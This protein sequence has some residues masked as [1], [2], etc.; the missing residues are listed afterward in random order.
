MHLRRSKLTLL[1]YKE[2]TNLD[3]KTQPEK[4]K[5]ICYYQMK[6]NCLSSFSIGDIKQ[7][8]IEF[9]YSEINPSR[10]K[11]KVTKGKEKCFQNS[12]NEKG[13]LTFIP[14]QIENLSKELNIYWND[15]ETIVSDSELI[16]ETKFC[17]KRGFL[18]KI[19]KQINNCYNSNCYDACA[20]MMRRLFE[21][22]LILSYQNNNIDD[23]IKNSDGKYKMLEKIVADAISNQT[24]KISRRI[25]DDFDTFRNVGNYSAHNITYTASQKDINDIK[26]SYRLM[27]DELYSKAGLQ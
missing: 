7:W 1:E 22:L 13:K 19:I 5:Y 2:K 9:G 23:I 10:L 24:L 27:L 14:I 16:N 15:S 25:S 26:L 3:V 11:D 6:E 18:D 12:K 8:F 17:G 4:A 21:I 20:V